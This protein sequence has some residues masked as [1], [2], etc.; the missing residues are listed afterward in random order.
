MVTVYITREELDKNPNKIKEVIDANVT[1]T[2]LLKKEKVDKLGNVEL[3]FD[4]KTQADKLKALEDFKKYRK[5]LIESTDYIMRFDYR[6]RVDN[7][8]EII[9]WCNELRDAPENYPD[10]IESFMIRPLPK[11][12]L[13]P[14]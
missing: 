3:L 8:Q 1:S 9:D 2:I 11:L 10:D 13:K 5:K 4:I 14:K 6:D 7:L 12:I